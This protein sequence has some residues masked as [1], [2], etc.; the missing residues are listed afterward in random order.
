MVVLR[1]L[2]ALGQTTIVDERN[3]T[4]YN[5]MDCGMIEL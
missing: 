1:I 3:G 2:V 4:W 5:L